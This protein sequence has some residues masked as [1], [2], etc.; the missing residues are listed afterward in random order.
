MTK[1]RDLGGVGVITDVNPS[2]LPVNAWG[3]GTNNVRFANG[4]V[5]RGMVYRS[6]F[7][8]DAPDNIA[9]VSS[10][11][12]DENTD[13]LVFPRATGQIT[14]YTGGAAT[15]RTPTG[16]VD[17]STTLPWSHC[18][19][20]GIS[21]L[22]NPDMPYPVYFNPLSGTRYA[23]LTNWDTNYKAA[24]LRPYK[25][26]LIA[27]D[28]TLS[29]VPQPKMVLWPSPTLDGQVP[30]S[31]DVADPAELAGFNI[32]AQMKDSIVDGLALGGEFFIYT[33]T[34]AWRMVY[35]GSRDVFAFDRAKFDGG[36]L[37]VN[38]VV[39]VE[40]RH[41]VF[42]KDD[43]YR[44]DGYGAQSI[45]EGRVK[46]FIFGS[47]NRAAV[48]YAFAVH[49]PVL[50]EV[51]FYYNSNES[52]I[53]FPGVSY[54]NRCA[55]FNYGNETWAFEDA[56]NLVG[57]TYASPASL[58]LWSTV[59][60]DWGASGGSWAQAGD[61]A[62]K[63]LCVVSRSAT[64]LSTTRCLVG[65]TIRNSRVALP[66]ATDTVK[67]AV[68][69]REGIDLDEGD[70][71]LHSWKRLDKAV[72]QFHPGDPSGTTKWRFGASGVPASSITWTNPATFDPATD[73]KVDLISSGRYLAIEIRQ[74]TMEDF[75]LSGINFSFKINGR[76]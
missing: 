4:R 24:V 36:I 66:L 27:L 29:G 70:D 31:W 45:V 5:N 50:K 60:G 6:W 35:T 20:S 16:W 65:D 53:G 61:T 74:D 12:T 33:P 30:P 3:R 37:N 64:G 22:T 62:R 67:D 32:L 42:G 57:A 28:V 49:E 7:T 68:L 18:V 48:K 41:Y 73:Y 71:S 44:H 17:I 59:T 38:C 21:Y 72:P 52:D 25:D 58:T 76:R 8:P 75:S 56:P 13:T 39:E 55:V 69:R 26:Y 63:A 34:E 46:D 43:I 19:L 1:V 2:D 54:C 15:D 47:L 51:R 40:G 14:T 23:Q 10:F 9:F 11:P